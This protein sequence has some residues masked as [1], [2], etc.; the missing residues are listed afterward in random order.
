MAGKIAEKA[1]LD[2]F[3]RFGSSGRTVF[4]AGVAY[5]VTLSD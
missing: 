3:L 1:R 4:A 2:W 5:G